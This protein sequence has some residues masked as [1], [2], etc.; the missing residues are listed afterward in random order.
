MLSPHLFF[1]LRERKAGEV[2]ER[3]REGREKREG[4]WVNSIKTR[5]EVREKEKEKNSKKKKKKKK[6]SSSTAC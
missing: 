2:T 4:G 3:G 6:N 5:E 1:Y